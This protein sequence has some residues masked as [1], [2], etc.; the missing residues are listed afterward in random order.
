MFRVILALSA[1]VDCLAQHILT[2]S[3]NS[4]HD[5]LLQH[6]K[7]YSSHAMNDICH[8]TYQRRCRASD[9]G[10][11]RCL[12]VLKAGGIS[13]QEPIIAAEDTLSHTKYGK[14][15]KEMWSEKKRRGD[16]S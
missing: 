14:R 16:F 13:L 11:M 6:M 4:I 1:Y 8:E 3:H 2:L 9:V 7:V 5:F 12:N 15:S 10:Y